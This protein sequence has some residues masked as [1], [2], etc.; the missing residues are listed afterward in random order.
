[1]PIP[2][3]R[4]ASVLSNTACTWRRCFGRPIRGLL[5]G[6][7]SVTDGMVIDRNESQLGPVR[8]FEPFDS[9]LSK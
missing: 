9:N 4:A 5:A 2:Q 3:G 6:G 1:M 8:G 7:E